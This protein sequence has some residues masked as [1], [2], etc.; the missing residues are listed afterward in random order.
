MRGRNIAVKELEG[1]DG[2]ADAS[3]AIDMQSGGRWI[4]FWSPDDDY[5]PGHPLAPVSEIVELAKLFDPAPDP[6]FE[7]RVR[8]LVIGAVHSIVRGWQTPRNARDA[9]T[10]MLATP[11]SLHPSRTLQLFLYLLA[12]VGVGKNLTNL[13]A[14]ARDTFEKPKGRPADETRRFF[15]EEL[16]RIAIDNGMDVR[17]PQHRDERNTAGTAFFVFVLGM[18]DVVVSRVYGASTAPPSEA[19]RRR[20]A[21][22]Q[23]SRIALLDALERAR[24]A[25]RRENENP[26][27]IRDSS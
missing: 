15:L 5:P 9:L 11:E 2:I 18:I 19:V 3:V 14:Q 21:T 24:E 26:L 17:L 16:V 10:A 25:V 6:W 22:F 8:G 1:R 13:I 7:P 12:M 20:L 23:C 4:A 27:E